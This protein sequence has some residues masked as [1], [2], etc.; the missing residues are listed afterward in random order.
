MERC[1]VPM[2]QGQASSIIQLLDPDHTGSVNYRDFLA[3]F[4]VQMPRLEAERESRGMCEAE[5]ERRGRCEAES[6]R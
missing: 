3:I 6:E 1:N 4:H 5:R 2:T